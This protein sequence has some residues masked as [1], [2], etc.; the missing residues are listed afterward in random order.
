MRA[1]R[2]TA[3][4]LVCGVSLSS[5]VASAQSPVL[6]GCSTFGSGIRTVGG[7]VLGAWVGF[8]GAK[9]KLSDWNETSRSPAAIRQRNQ[10]TIGGAIAGAVIGNLA[11]RHP[12]RSYRGSIARSG[13]PRVSSAR[14]PITQEEIQRAGIFGSVYELVYALR[15]NWLNDRGLQSISEAARIVRDSLGKESTVA[16]ETQLIVY[17]DNMKLGTIGELRGLPVAGIIGVV[18]YDASEATFK[19]GTGHA[20]GAIQVLSVTTD[21]PAM[22]RPPPQKLVTPP[23][24]P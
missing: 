13:Q 7:A 15:R 4:A 5:E 3:V 20:H 23:S 9:M 1:V 11:F 22:L 10:I 16:G 24:L 12:C 17:L 2:W 6:G 8:V 19:W 18:Y 14:R 21:A